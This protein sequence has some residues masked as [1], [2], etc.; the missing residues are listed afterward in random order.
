MEI[1][2]FQCESAFEEL[3]ENHNMGV[4]RIIIGA[5]TGEVQEAFEVP[6][7]MRLVDWRF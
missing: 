1:G 2:D 5:E 7:D 6:N 4:Y 3:G